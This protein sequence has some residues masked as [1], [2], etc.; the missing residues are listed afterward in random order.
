MAA[1]ALEN[2]LSTGALTK[3][4]FAPQWE[5]L[6]PSSAA[7]TGDQEF[8]F[9]SRA[10]T[11][12]VVVRNTAVPTAAS[13]LPDWVKPTIAAFIG[14]QNLTDNWDSYGGKAINRDLI[15]QSLSIIGMVMQPNLPAPSVVPMGDG[16]L[17]IEWHRK[18]QDLGL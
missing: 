10:S 2:Q 5:P 1:F 12:R 6:A 8:T 13:P 15:N 16:G 17:Q 3:N 18:Q 14:I 11:Y 4:Q 7:M 9:P